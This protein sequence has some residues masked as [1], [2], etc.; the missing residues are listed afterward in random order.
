MRQPSRDVTQFENVRLTCVRRHKVRFEELSTVR[1]SV[2]SDPITY[3]AEHS[4]EDRPI[5]SAHSCEIFVL[6]TPKTN[7]R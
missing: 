5:K 7:I 6:H 2:N 1:P 3:W 4:V